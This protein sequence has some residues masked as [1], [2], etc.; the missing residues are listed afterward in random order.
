M[1]SSGYG[2]R[3]SSW[4]ATQYDIILPSVLALTFAYTLTGTLQE[5]AE[6][7]PFDCYETVDRLNVV[8]EQLS[9]L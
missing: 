4:A 9:S 6:K 2:F 5:P 7:L 1:Q 3:D 8:T